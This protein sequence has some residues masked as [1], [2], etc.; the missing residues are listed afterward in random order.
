[1]VIWKLMLFKKTRLFQRVVVFV[2]RGTIL[3]IQER[4]MESLRPCKTTNKEQKLR[5]N[6]IMMT[7][8]HL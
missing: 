6:I 5:N 4:G 3:D 1:M 8:K 2:S 7:E